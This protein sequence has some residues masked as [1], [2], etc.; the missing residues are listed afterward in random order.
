VLDVVGVR[1]KATHV[2]QDIADLN[3]RLGHR[4]G[5]RRGPGLHRERMRRLKA[6][7]PRPAAVIEAPTPIPPVP[8][9]TAT[10]TSDGVIKASI[11]E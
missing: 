4:A 3:Q 7:S 2:R 6:G 9:R 10:V 11:V 1:T 8:A 5:H